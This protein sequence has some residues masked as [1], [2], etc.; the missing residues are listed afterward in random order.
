M[1]QALKLQLPAGH[2]LQTQ[3]PVLHLLHT[4]HPHWDRA[5]RSPRYRPSNKFL[6][7]TLTGCRS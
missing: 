2:P 4:R 7:A 3:L 6:M 1:L 5:L